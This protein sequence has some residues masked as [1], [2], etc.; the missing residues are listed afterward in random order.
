MIDV[1]SAQTGETLEHF[2]ALA[3]EYVTWMSAEFRR[4]Y[5][6]ADS[7]EIVSAHDY[8][9]IRKKFPGEHVPPDGCLLLAMNDKQACGCV[10]IGRLTGTICE[11][12]TLFVRPAFRGMGVGR[13]LVEA[14]LDAGRKFGYRC[15][16]LD[17]LAFLESALMLYRSVGFHDIKPYRD[18][19]APL[20][21]YIRFLERDLADAT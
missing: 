20:K 21:P 13:M 9:D 12:R 10:A 3:Q 2:I 17:T 14:S 16:R 7:N 4:H 1:V 6:E 15:M 5:P 18:I 19:S 8:D 11:M